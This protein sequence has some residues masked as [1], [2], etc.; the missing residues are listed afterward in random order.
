MK[1]SE[2][3]QLIIKESNKIKNNQ[4]HLVMKEQE[5]E[6]GL[7]SARGLL[8]LKTVRVV[9]EGDGVKDNKDKIEKWLKEYDPDH[10]VQY[11]ENTGKYVG[12]F[13]KS[14]IEQFNNRLKPL[15]VRIKEKD[16][17]KSLKPKK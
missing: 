1:K 8:G 17:V 4:K 16:Q 12:T 11:Y 6:D 5:E 3:K 9:I 10:K 2:L 13:L 7:H 15:N 14:K